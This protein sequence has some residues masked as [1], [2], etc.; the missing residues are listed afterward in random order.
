MK[1]IPISAGEHIAKTY[2]YDQIV[3]IGRKVSSGEHVTTYGINPE[4]CEVAGK[5]GN[6]IKY[7]IMKWENDPRQLEIDRLTKCL[8]GANDQA[9][10]FERKY[11][12]LIDAEEDKLHQMRF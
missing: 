4:N 3:I 1:E 10:E 8:K 9:E 5:I 6:F 2:D 7:Q 11:Y 12:L